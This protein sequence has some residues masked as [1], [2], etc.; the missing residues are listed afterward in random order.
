[1]LS[2]HDSHSFMCVSTFILFYFSSSGE[3]PGVLKTRL[4][5]QVITLDL[6]FFLFIS[7]VVASFVNKQRVKKVSVVKMF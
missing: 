7:H 2:R 6:I 4:F 3:H 5:C 1:V